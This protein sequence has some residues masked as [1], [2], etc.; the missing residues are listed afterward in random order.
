MTGNLKLAFGVSRPAKPAPS[1]VLRQVETEA[2]ALAVSIA[3]GNH[4]LAFIA[5][6]IGKSTA[7]VSR[8]QSGKRNIPNRLIAPLCAATGSLLLAQ[9]VEL[10]RALEGVGE[11][12]RLAQLL[13][14]AA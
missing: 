7:Y 13:R 5:A 3:A 6:S 10:Q 11:V 14:D 4:K 8:L 12:E 9:F 2:Q 1:K